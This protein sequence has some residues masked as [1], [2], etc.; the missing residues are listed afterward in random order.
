MAKTCVT[1][2][3]GKVMVLEDQQAEN[4]MQLTQK[5]ENL[6][7]GQPLY[8]GEALPGTATSATKWRIK[9]MEYDNGTSSPPT[10]VTWAD[11]VSTFIKEWDERT[12]YSYS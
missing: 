11:G 7:S 3:D 8:I 2:S 5:M 9:K 1:R 4:E 10:G 6:S 12:S